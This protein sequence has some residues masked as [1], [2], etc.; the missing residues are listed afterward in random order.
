MFFKSVTSITT[1]DLQNLL[2]EEAVEN[3]RLEFKQGIPSKN[4]MLRKLSSFA[5][6][7]DGY[8]VIGVEEDGTSGTISSIPGVDIESG[9]K[10]KIISWCFEGISA[11]LYAEVSEP[12]PSPQDP[13]KVCYV[14]YAAENDLAPHFINGKKGCYICCPAPL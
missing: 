14:I 10:Q 12:I 11:P 7:F 2:D 9:F 8:L 1:D 5:N 4:E 6:T 3:V 13:N